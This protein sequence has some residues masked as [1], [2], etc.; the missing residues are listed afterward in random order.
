[1]KRKNILAL[2]TL[3]AVLV[4]ALAGCGANDDRIAELEAENAEL[5]A[6]VD[7]LTAQ[8]ES[9]G[10]TLGL[11]SCDLEAT[12]WSSAN[13]AT[14]TLTAVPLNYEEGQT[15]FFSIWLEGEEVES[16]ACTWDGTSYTAAA[17]LNAADGYCYYC[18]LFGADG[19]QAEVD[20]NTPIHPINEDL[21]NMETALNSY[22]YVMVESSELSG[23]TLTITGGYAQAQTP[24][25]TLSGDEV[26]CSGAVLILE[27]NGEEVSR[28]EAALEETE[29]EN[30]Y[31]ADIAGLAFEIPAMEDDQ[32]LDLHLEVALSDGQIL[33]APGG[34]WF[35]TGGELL[36]AV[37]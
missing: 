36:L 31:E 16:V 37:G 6:Q 22:C 34:S 9:Y 10:N 26:T 28:Q 32:Q 8:L 17:D 7:T 14:V 23:N 30:C 35:Y 12:S 33:T 3:A 21:I 5:K 1:M 4:M 20:V 11:A 15:A 2:V 29:V 19:A 27:F 18:I 25:I 24:R 13:G